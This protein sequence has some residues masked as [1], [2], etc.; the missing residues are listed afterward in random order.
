MVHTCNPSTQET[1]AEGPQFNATLGYIARPYLKKLKIKLKKK[2]QD[3]KQ[4]FYPHL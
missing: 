4:D 1:E 3:M 2:R